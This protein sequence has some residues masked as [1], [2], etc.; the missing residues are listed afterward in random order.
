MTP[1]FTLEGKVEAVLVA[2]TFGS[3]VSTPVKKIQVIRNHGVRGDNH[4]G[5]RLADVREKELLE[6]GL[7]KGIEIANHREFSLV[8]IEELSSIA[9]AM[10]LPGPIPHGCLGENLVLSGIPRLTE[11]PS[12]TIFFFRKDEKHL[13]TAILVV[14]GENTPCIVPGEAIERHFSIPKLAA[15][16]PKAAMGVRGV[17]GSIYCSGH[18]HEGDIVIAKVP[19]QRIYNPPSSIVTTQDASV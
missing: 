19:P 10:E 6:F 16:F 4:A 14:W 5:T 2:S 8:S 12:G 11:L 17:V 7:P 18:I 1:S 9:S 3:Q 13:R 15:R